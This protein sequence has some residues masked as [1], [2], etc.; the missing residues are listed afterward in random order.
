[1]GSETFLVWIACGNTVRGTT[2]AD[3][4]SIGTS[5]CIGVGNVDIT[6]IG[7]KGIDEVDGAPVVNV[8][9]VDPDVT[10]V[11]SNAVNVLTDR[12]A[13]D[14]VTGVDDVVVAVVVGAAEV[15]VTVVGV[16]VVVGV[17]VDVVVVGV[18]VEVVDVV[19]VV[20]VVVDVVEVVVEVVV[21]VVVVGVSSA[22]RDS[23][24]VTEKETMSLTQDPIT[25]TDKKNNTNQCL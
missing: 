9:G 16:D 3:A 14:I 6:E 13:E 25:C 10:D 1:M 21:D 18:V 5:V 23:S 15:V 24:R 4:T 2:I 12:D 22:Q 17:V 20:V 7:D 11:V 19:V 8:D